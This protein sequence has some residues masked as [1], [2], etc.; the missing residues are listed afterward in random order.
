[1]GHYTL[2]LNIGIPIKTGHLSIFPPSFVNHYAITM[3]ELTTF[4][5]VLKTI[6]KQRE[7]ENNQV[8]FSKK[9]FVDVACSIPVSD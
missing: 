3:E 6:Y 1:M 7:Y 4:A 5:A 9:V 8:P 2:L